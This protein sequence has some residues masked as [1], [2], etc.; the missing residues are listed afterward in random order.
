MS[1]GE[2]TRSLATE[3]QIFTITLDE[4]LAVLAQPRQF[5]G[6]GGAA[7]KPPLREFG[8]DPVQRAAGGGQGGPVRPLRHRRRDERLARPGRPAGGDVAERA[9]ELLAVRREQVAEKG[10]AAKKAARTTKAA[11]AAAKP[12]EGEGG[13]EAGQDLTWSAAATRARGQLRWSAA[14]RRPVEGGR[15]R[16]AAR[17]SAPPLPLTCERHGPRLLHRLRGE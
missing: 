13:E 9:Y 3:E 5:G 12:S 17:P 7:P 2:E 16:L 8:T 4:A 6:R 10:P 1:K 14:R 15:S 11:K